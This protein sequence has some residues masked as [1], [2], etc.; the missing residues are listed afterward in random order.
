MK[1]PAKCT[2]RDAGLWI[3][4]GAEA[5]GAIPAGKS[6]LSET[7]YANTDHFVLPGGSFRSAVS[8]RTHGEQGSPPRAAEGG[9][10]AASAAWNREAA[11]G[12]AVGTNFKTSRPVQNH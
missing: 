4:W 2:F 1:G 12:R 9:K 11:A 3:D 7:N 6:A 5:W 8:E 10:F